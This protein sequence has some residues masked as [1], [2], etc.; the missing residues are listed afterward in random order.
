LN[1]DGCSIRLEFRNNC[2]LKGTGAFP[3][4]VS[5][6]TLCSLVICFCLFVRFYFE[7]HRRFATV[8]MMYQLSGIT[9]IMVLNLVF[10]VCFL[11]TSTFVFPFWF[12]TGGSHPAQ[13]DPYSEMTD[14]VFWVDKIVLILSCLVH[15]GFLYQF[16]VAIHSKWPKVLLYIFVAVGVCITCCIGLPVPFYRDVYRGSGGRD[17]IPFLIAFYSIVYGF[18]MLE[19]VLFLIYGLILLQ[20]HRLSHGFDRK[21]WKTLTLLVLLVLSN[22]GRLIAVMYTWVRFY[23]AVSSGN[24][25]ELYFAGFDY[26]LMRFRS[27]QSGCLF[28][29]FGFLIPDLVPYIVLLLLLFDVV[30]QGVNVAEQKDSGEP[31][32][33]R[34]V[35]A[36]YEI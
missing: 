11:M 22:V 5:G 18:Q 20:G 4:G 34:S 27:H 7:K 21:M 1:P 13:M 24:Y 33:E 17:V 9:L 19:S 26:F 14:T 3:I 15:L 30:Y 16:V 35:P 32:L 31:L 6:I 12:V 28:Y 25:R 36:A 8:E 10:W 2:T 29:V 23:F